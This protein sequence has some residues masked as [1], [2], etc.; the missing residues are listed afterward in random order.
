MS[1]YCRAD[2]TKGFFFFNF[3][4]IYTFLTQKTEVQGHMK[5]WHETRHDPVTARCSASSSQA[6][7]EDQ[8]ADN[9]THLL[10]G[11]GVSQQVLCRQQPQITK[12]ETCQESVTE[13]DT[14]FN[15]AAE[16]RHTLFSKRIKC[17]ASN[18]GPDGLKVFQH[19]FAYF[20]SAGVREIRVLG[21]FR[22]E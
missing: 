20:K 9:D 3:Y 4:F 11:G 7:R 17:L 15:T 6:L 12:K 14:K 10:T 16:F 19:F 22:K 1:S 18:T 13:K 2:T 8:K 21:L 5:N